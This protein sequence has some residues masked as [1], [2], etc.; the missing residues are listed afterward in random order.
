MT[1]TIPTAITPDRLKS[2][3][4]GKKADQNKRF[5]EM[6]RAVI[7]KHKHK[8]NFQLSDEQL[9]NLDYADLA[10]I[11]IATVNG[12]L[13]IVLGKGKDFSDAS[14]AKCVVSQARNN[15]KR[16]KY[17]KACW[18]HSCQVSGV[19]DKEG[20]LRVIVYNTIIKDFEYY[21]IP[22]NSYSRNMK[23]LEIILERANLP[24]GEVPKFTGVATTNSK[25]HK[26]KCS[27]FEDM[28]MR[29]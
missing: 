11:A 18:M 7:N 19:T 9:L 25:W 1:T 28:A 24:P 26:F 8:C 14:D 3:W 5:S 21:F 4:Y 13:S 15:V 23:V 6:L 29:Q 22:Y 17:G 27:S 2:E 10:E 12:S 20:A 16:N